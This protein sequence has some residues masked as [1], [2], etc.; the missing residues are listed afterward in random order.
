[1][2]HVIIHLK[3]VTTGLRFKKRRVHRMKTRKAAGK[4]IVLFA[5]V[6]A[7]LFAVFKYREIK[8]WRSMRAASYTGLSEDTAIPRR[9]KYI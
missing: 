7:V 2:I 1:M 4:R 9:E 3:P 6:S 8:M 5:A